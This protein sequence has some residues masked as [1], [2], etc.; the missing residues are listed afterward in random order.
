MLSYVQRHL[1]LEMKETN[2][3]AAG[4]AKEKNC[5]RPFTC[6][7]TSMFIEDI[8]RVIQLGKGNGCMVL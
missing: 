3:R 5:N 8:I 2:N 7:P 4:N 1:R 6:S